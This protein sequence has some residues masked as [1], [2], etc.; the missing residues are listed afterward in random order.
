M[1]DQNDVPAKSDWY[2]HDESIEEIVF[3]T[4]DGTV[5][6]IREYPDTDCFTDAIEGATYL[7]S[8][9][10]VADLPDVEAFSEQETDY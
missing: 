1:A 7:G 8:H 3:A 4:E 9:P 6:T 5:M 2:R 10:E